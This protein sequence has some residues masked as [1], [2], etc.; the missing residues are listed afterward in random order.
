MVC[1][2]GIN[3]GGNYVELFKVGEE[4]V[5]VSLRVIRKRDT[6]GVRASNRLVVNVGKIHDVLYLHPV[7][8]DDTP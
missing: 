2:R 5:L 1:S 4:R 8:L 3:V 7:K 6:G